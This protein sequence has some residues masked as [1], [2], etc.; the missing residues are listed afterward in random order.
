MSS[1][2]RCFH[3]KGVLGDFVDGYAVPPFEEGH[4]FFFPNVGVISSVLLWFNM[5]NLEIFVGPPLRAGLLK[6]HGLGKELVPVS[7]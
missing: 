6:M 4:D 5:L 1:D 3:E 7:C 2:P